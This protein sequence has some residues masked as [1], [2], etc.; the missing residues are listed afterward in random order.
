MAKAENLSAR[1]LRAAMLSAALVAFPLV[2]AHA[3]GAGTDA[4]ADSP[5]DSPRDFSKEAEEMSEATLEAIEKFNAMVG[6]MLESFEHWIDDMPRYE[7]PEMLPNGD[8]IIRRIPKDATPPSD[9]TEKSDVT[10]L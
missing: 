5:A 2:P 1:L 4:P 10:D 9:E 7:A 8:I 6:A 3:A